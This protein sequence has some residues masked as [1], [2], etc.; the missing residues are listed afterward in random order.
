MDVSAEGVIE[1][2]NRTSQSP[3]LTDVKYC[4]FTVEIFIFIRK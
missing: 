3:R 4:D 1:N 2:M